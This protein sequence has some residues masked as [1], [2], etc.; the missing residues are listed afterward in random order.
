MTQLDLDFESVSVDLVLKGEDY[1]PVR[2]LERLRTQLG[3]I[4]ALVKDG[5]WRTVRSIS[6]QL[7]EQHH[8]FFPENSVQ[9]QLRNL[10]KLGVRVERRHVSDGLSEY[11]VAGR[12]RKSEGEP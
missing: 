4:Y 11:R 2:D 5:E 3:R 6:R 9:A 1:D 8:V 7:E 10:R 12:I